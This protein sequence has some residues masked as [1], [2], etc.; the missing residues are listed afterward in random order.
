MHEAGFPAMGSEA[1]IVVVGAPRRLLADAIARVEDLE[2]KWSRFRPTSDVAR[3]NELGALHVSDETCLLVRRAL[4]GWRM[5]GG[6]FDPTTLGDV[7]RAGYPN[8]PQASEMERG[9]GGIVI[10]GSHVTLPA[11]VG[12]DPGGI[13]KGLAAD[14]VVDELMAQGAHGACVNL[15]GDVAVAGAGPDAADWTIDIVHEWQ[16]EP[17][18][19]VALQRGAVATSTTLRRRWTTPTGAAHHLI[20]PHTGAPSTSSINTVSVVAAHA[21]IAEVMAKALLLRADGFAAIAGSAIEALT[22]DN[23]GHV[24]TTPQFRKFALAA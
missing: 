7:I 19:R 16:A 9:C 8:G 4:E 11:G 14:I 12:F 10:A 24:A 2:A 15:G 13:G 3:L 18:R 23:K 1:H 22:V 20:D 21:W 17:I 5:S 6:W